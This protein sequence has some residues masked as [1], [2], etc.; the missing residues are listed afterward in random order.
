MPISNTSNNFMLWFAGVGG[1]DAIAFVSGDP[2][3]GGGN[4]AIALTYI[5]NGDPNL[6]AP[7][8]IV[9]DTVHD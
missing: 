1:G 3:V 7:R 6:F 8:V 4:T 2:A 5:L 9:L